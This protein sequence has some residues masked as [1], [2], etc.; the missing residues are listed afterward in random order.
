LPKR[1]VPV[2]VLEFAMR[3]EL[4]VGYDD[5]QVAIFR[6]TTT[7]TVFQ[8]QHELTQI[9]FS[10]D[11]E[12]IVCSSRDGTI[13]IR[14][15]RSSSSRTIRV[16]AP[17]YG[18]QFSPDASL[19]MTRSEAGIKLW[20]TANG[21]EVFTINVEMPVAASFTRNGDALLTAHKNGQVFKWVINGKR[22]ADAAE[23]VLSGRL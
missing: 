22:V 21:L 4:A 9:A 5:G 6:G 1:K 13:T 20:S 16:G 19:V 23:R 17:V 11:S 12:Q 3:G 2:R 10:R 14:S 8:A 18:C 7:N 15:V